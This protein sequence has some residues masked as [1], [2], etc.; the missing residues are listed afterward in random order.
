MAV[1]ARTYAQA[2]QAELGKTVLAVE[3]DAGGFA[4]RGFSIE[5]K[6]EVEPRVVARVSQIAALLGALGPIKATAGHSGADL[7]PLIPAGVPGIGVVTDGRLYFDYH[8]T[9]ADTF[10]KVSKEDLDL[11]VATL[12]TVAFVI[13]DMPESLRE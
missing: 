12:A 13:A 1:V 6:P 10:D 4:P 11:C 3:A 2:H 8:H 5:T 9:E 7:I